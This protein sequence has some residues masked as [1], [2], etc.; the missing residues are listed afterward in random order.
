MVTAGTSATVAAPIT[1]VGKTIIK[2]GLATSIAGYVMMANSNSNKAQGYNR[3]KY[4]SHGIQ[5]NSK[6][7]WKSTGKGKGRID[8]EN[9]NPKGRKG[10][11]HYQEGN[12]KYLYD[13]KKGQ[14]IG[15]PK[16]IN[17]LLQEDK[18]VQNAIK[19]GEKY[20]GI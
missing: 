4:A 10:Q 5:T 6:T 8:V 2:A 19:K 3:G 16:R 7:L 14:F 9:P 18:N 1:V 11:I 12:K 17:K 20:L 15:A 13:S